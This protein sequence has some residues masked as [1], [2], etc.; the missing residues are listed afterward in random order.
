MQ[1]KRKSKKCKEDLFENLLK[2]QT[3]EDT[4]RRTK[5]F[6]A[7][8]LEKATDNFNQNRIIGKGGQGIVYKGMLYD[9]SIV[10]IK[11]L[12]HVD[13]DQVEEFINEV[14][15]L[16]QINHR[17]V[18]KLLGC[19]LATEVPLLVYEF[20]PNGTLLDLIHDSNTQ[21]PVP[22][23]MRLKIAADLAGALAYLHYAASV[24]IYHRD[25]K[26]SNFLLDQNFV[27][28]VADFGISRSIGVD[29]T[30]LT[31]MVKGT[32]GYF[33]PEYFQSHKYTEKSDVFS[34]GVVLAELLTGRKPIFREESEEM[35]ISLATHFAMSMDE[36]NIDFILDPQVSKH[37]RKEEVIAVA[38]LTQRCL[39]R[40]RRK[41]PT[42]KEV[43][44]EMESLRLPQ[45]SATVEEVYED[46]RV[47]ES[48]PMMI[49]YN[50]NKGTT[51]SITETSTTSSD[52]HPFMF[53]AI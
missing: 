11:K 19:C 36:N 51:S 52:I 22:W 50:Q 38:R 18:V 7:K 47:Y 21:L 6:S 41:R 45:M 13:E 5:L 2:Q 1:E 34:F 30:H 39:N 14:V 43:S 53:E 31:T 23:N 46:A 15:I 25:I 17:N 27:V 32:F 49:S 24:P 29:Q 10:A 28:K 12:K 40:E 9:G 20:V 44:I 8:E 35:E 26:S 42:M 33:D 3:N 37:N 48:N 16:S 4:F